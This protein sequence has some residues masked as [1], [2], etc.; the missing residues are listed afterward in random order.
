[1]K[2]SGRVQ[3]LAD[4]SGT[5]EKLAA[6]T[7]AQ[8]QAELARLRQQASDLERYRNEYL[9]PLKE[10]ARPVVGYEVQKLRLFVARI[11]QALAQL[12]G[13][14]RQA[15]GAVVKAESVWQEQR[16][17]TQ[18]MNDVAVRARA[19]EERRAEKVLQREIDDRPRRGPSA[20]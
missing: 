7:L 15:E 16:R 20:S 11:D 6:Q 19:V 17:R 10:G 14:I 3:R 2:K 12:Q 5:V 13:R 1:M 9:H 4:L 18:T 8:A